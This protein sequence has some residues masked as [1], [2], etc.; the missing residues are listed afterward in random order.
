M[1]NSTAVITDAET[2]AA[3][4][5][6]A[7]SQAKSMTVSGEDQDLTG[8]ISAALE[9]LYQARRILTTAKAGLDAADPMLTLTNNIL[10]TLS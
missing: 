6:T 3:S 8:M 4:T 9:A 2:L 1:P 5:P 7:L 10:G